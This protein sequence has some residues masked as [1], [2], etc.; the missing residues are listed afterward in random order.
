MKSMGAAIL[1]IFGLFTQSVDAK[2]LGKIK[3]EPT[4]DSYLR[5]KRQVGVGAASD[6]VR[7]RLA[8]L[9]LLNNEPKFALIQLARIKNGI[10]SNTLTLTKARAYYQN[11]QFTQSIEEY[12]KIEKASK[13]WPVALEEKAWAYVKLG[14]E[15]KALAELTTVLSPAF[16]NSIG[17]EPYYLRALSQL[18]ICDYPGALK[19]SAEFKNKHE[20]KIGAL[21]SLVEGRSI[22]SKEHAHLANT[23]V[24]KAKKML[25]EIDRTVIRLGLI[26]G[27]VIQ[28]IQNA[29][30]NR[31][32]KAKID[33]EADQNTLV[34]PKNDNET[35]EDELGNFRVGIKRCPTKGSKTL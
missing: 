35:W 6:A 3:S 26:E 12:S 17:P 20:G 11:K 1:V 25:E 29:E 22:E 32:E 18:R 9:A 31:D 16:Q 7:F 24:P 15:D 2:S 21:Q 28:R 27:E 14:E 5:L 13:L 10:E 33:L 23:P 34:F 8:R 30:A 19:T 4:R